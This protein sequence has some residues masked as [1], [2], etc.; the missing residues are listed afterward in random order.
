MSVLYLEVSFFFKWSLHISILKWSSFTLF[1][2]KRGWVNRDT[3]A[4][5]EDTEE[6]LVWD[7]EEDCENDLEEEDS[8]TK[9]NLDINF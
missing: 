2:G 8:D 5:F 4:S 1:K 6:E 7:D 3:I 9:D